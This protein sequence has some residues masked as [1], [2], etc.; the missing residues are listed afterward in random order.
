VFT[1]TGLPLRALWPYHLA[2]PTA[3]CG[4]HPSAGNESLRDEK[5]T[6]MT[7]SPTLPQRDDLDAEGRRQRLYATRQ[8]YKYDRDYL[9][10]LSM[11]F[12]PHAWPPSLEE[13]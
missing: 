11:L 3:L 7:A 2:H 13:V 5:E 4:F 8:Q 1:R 6:I 9:A 10:P 12:I